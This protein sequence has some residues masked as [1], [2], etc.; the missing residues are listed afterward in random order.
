MSLIQLLKVRVSFLLHFFFPAAERS[1]N[2]LT[3]LSA[4]QIAMISPNSG[5]AQAIR[6][7]AE[8][9]GSRIV[10]EQDHSTF[11]LKNHYG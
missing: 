3:V 4:E 9:C 7:I 8:F 6:Q 1:V 2:I 5:F 10:A 11:P